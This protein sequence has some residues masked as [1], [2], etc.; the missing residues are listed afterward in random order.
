MPLNVDELRRA[1]RAWASGVTV[2]TAAHDGVRHGMT[3]SSF[4]S[5]SLDPPLVLVSLQTATRTHALVERSGHFGVTILSAAQAG[6]SDR[7]A[8]RVPDAEDRLAGLETETLV[9]G[10]PLLAG[11]LAQ[12]DCRVRQAI[13]A[14]GNTLFLGEVLGLR[15]GETRR[16]L[17]YFDR[18]YRELKE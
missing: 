4:T 9:S 11:G 1:M 3:V 7:F 5:V 18:G 12:L 17:V 6:L 15:V 14:G 13:P 16:P 8:G 10:A 2:V